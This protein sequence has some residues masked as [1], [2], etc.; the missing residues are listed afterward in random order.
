VVAENAVLSE[1]L[2]PFSDVR[3]PL[4]LTFALP[5]FVPIRL[6]LLENLDADLDEALYPFDTPYRAV[7]TAPSLLTSLSSSA[8]ALL[9]CAL[10]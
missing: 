3:V 2:R 4:I 5:T 6:M 7:S 10:I 8:F 1:L 9:A